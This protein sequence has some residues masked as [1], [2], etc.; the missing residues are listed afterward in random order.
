MH[1]LLYIH[2]YLVHQASSVLLIIK[3]LN[4]H[5]RF[6]YAD[7]RH[8]IRPSSE[9]KKCAFVLWRK[10]R[11][12]RRERDDRRADNREISREHRKERMIIVDETFDHDFSS[13]K[14]SKG[15]WQVISSAVS[16]ETTP[17]DSSKDNITPPG[18][19]VP[20]RYVERPWP[21]SRQQGVLFEW[22][23]F[24]APVLGLFVQRCNPTVNPE[25]YAF[26][27]H[28]ESDSTNTDF[29]CGFSPNCFNPA[30]CELNWATV[31]E[32]ILIKV[33]AVRLIVPCVSAYAWYDH[34][35]AGQNQE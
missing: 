21:S 22:C 17:I 4:R 12:S 13:G 28:L 8:Y 11:E 20:S 10:R 6:D 9:I 27:P 3:L 23:F 18:L 14:L 16:L 1:L 35:I 34:V 31:H 15:S 33:A 29:S 5:D 7:A 25:L 30:N 2:I 19:T 32:E 24:F 26:V